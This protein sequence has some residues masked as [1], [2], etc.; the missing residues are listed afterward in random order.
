[1]TPRLQASGL[2]DS[3]VIARILQ[4]TR[5]IAVVGLSTDPAKPSADV[6]AYLQRAG[7]RIIPIH[8]KAETLLGEKVYATLDAVPDEIDLVNVFRPAAEAEAWAEAA[9]RVGA[10]AW[11][12]QLGLV[13][14]AAAEKARAGGLDVVMDRC[15]KIEHRR[16]VQTYRQQLAQ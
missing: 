8:P 16:L 6:A 14:E 10:K 3:A 13:N 12:L 2:G 9:V 11:W 15:T 1:M 4:R 5:T 7:Y